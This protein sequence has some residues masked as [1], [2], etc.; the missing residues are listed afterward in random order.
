MAPRALRRVNA[1][2]TLRTGGSREQLQ[3]G[4]KAYL[5]TIWP[6][7]VAGPK[8]A[9]AS[10]S[11]SRYRSRRAPGLTA[12][13]RR[14]G[15]LPW[16]WCRSR[17]SRP[18]PRRP[19][20]RVPAQRAVGA[21]LFRRSV[22]QQ[23]HVRDQ[24]RAPTAVGRTDRSVLPAARGAGGWVGRVGSSPERA[25][26]APEGGPRPD[27]VTVPVDLAERVGLRPESALQPRVEPRE[28]P[29]PSA[30]HRR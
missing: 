15:C 3:S 11:R 4:M 1:V 21:A 2:W 10:G 19:Q 13:G 16:G 7:R 8:S 22:P 26:P 24:R 29:C 30:A 5:P 9:C 28:T 25:R 6:R 14:G 12:G 23:G 18:G 27:P 20:S 17:T